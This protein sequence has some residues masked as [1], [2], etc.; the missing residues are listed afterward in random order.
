MWGGQEED[1]A[2]KRD[3]LVMNLFLIKPGLPSAVFPPSSDSSIPAAS[4]QAFLL[5]SS[6]SAN[7]TIESGNEELRAGL[8]GCLAS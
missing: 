2:R 6:L 4:N 8:L 5:N 1:A 3:Y 7:M